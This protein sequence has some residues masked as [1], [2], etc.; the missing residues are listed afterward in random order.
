MGCAKSHGL[1]TGAKYTTE[2]GVPLVLI[3]RAMAGVLIWDLRKR[4]AARIAAE[5]IDCN[6]MAKRYRTR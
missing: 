5:D 1:S 2:F 4:A 3:R 6:D